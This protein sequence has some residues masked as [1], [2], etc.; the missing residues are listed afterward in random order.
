M[1][2]QKT[3]ADE[4]VAHLKTLASPLTREIRSM[5]FETLL[6]L[7]SRSFSHFLNA[8]ERYLPLLR[9]LTQ[10]SE[11]RRT[12]LDAVAAY[13]TE[14]A[15]MRVVVADKYLQYGVVDGLDVVGYVFD[16][17]PADAMADAPDA[18]TDFHAWEMLRMALDKVIG[19]V[20]AARRKASELEAEDDKARARKAAEHLE[21]GGAMGMDVDPEV[22]QQSPETLAAQKSLAELVDQQDAVL[23]A[24]MKAFVAELL[25]WCFGGESQG[26]SAVLT[27]VES[28]ED[29]QWPVRARWGWY[30][31]FVRSVS[32]LGLLEF[33]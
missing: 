13:W 23:V 33:S 2:R 1:Y 26:L 10:T 27:L 29:G 5:A 30:R 24:V 12:A 14:S 31:E 17:A 32:A 4:V 22:P 21:H 6:H 9:A 8:T 3:P 20:S 11:D 19:R 16:M 28:G 15:Q 7:G 18:W 25:P